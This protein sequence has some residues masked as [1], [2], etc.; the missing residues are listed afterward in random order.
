MKQQDYKKIERKS[1]AKFLFS[2]VMWTIIAWALIWW[3]LVS[4]YRWEVSITDPVVI[5][6]IS[7]NLE[8]I[9]ENYS[10]LESK[11]NW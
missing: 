8:V 9:E 10:E 6:D 2:K 1:S 5:E 4:I 7:N 3:T 11:L